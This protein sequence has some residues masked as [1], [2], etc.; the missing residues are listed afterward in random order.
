MPSFQSYRDR[1]RRDADAGYQRCRWAAVA[2]KSAQ[3]FQVF[4]GGGRDLYGIQSQGR[5]RA[6]DAAEQ[7]THFRGQ[8]FSSVR[9]IC[10]RIA[11][12]P[13]RLARVAKAIKGRARRAVE[14]RQYDRRALVEFVTNRLGMSV[15]ANEQIEVIDQHPL[16]DALERPSPSIPGWND[17]SL[18]Y[19][20]VASL[21]MTGHAYLW[22]P[23]VQGTKEIWHLPS[24]WVRAR[25]TEQGL[26][27]A[28]LVR[29]PGVADDTELPADSIAP[30]WYPDPSNPL[31]GLGPMEAGARAVLVDEFVQEAQ[32]RA[33]QMGIHPGAVIKVGSTI[34]AE[35]KSASRPRLL[36]HQ[37]D[38]IQSAINARYRGLT[39]FGEP[40]IADALVDDIAPYGNTPKQMDFGG[41]M[42]KTQ[43]R[44]EQT[45]GTNPYIAGAA[46]LGSRAEA[47]EARYQ[48]AAEV[49]NP[50]I[51]LL[52]RVFTICVVPQ[53][54]TM[55][56]KNA[57]PGLED[58]ERYVLFIE[59]CHPQDVEIDQEY[60][61]LAAQ[62]GGATIDEFRS[63]CLRLPP[64]AWGGQR[65]LM[66]TSAK[67]DDAQPIAV[68]PGSEPPADP[69][70]DDEEQAL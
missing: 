15:K 42:D 7:Y 56:Q 41:N 38:Q 61:K 69:L 46:S 65:L 19:V 62:T 37:L 63:Q 2:A 55:R 22:F 17:W 40:F 58:G 51:E 68:A 26:F 23:V 31:R 57:A 16:L 3:P 49:V 47:S 12:Q 24:H 28:W 33:F 11:G 30:F 13:I 70:A 59:P 43:A 14:P 27:Q 66:V 60:W 6:F 4:T 45:F 25:S 44:V 32:K 20:I 50:K 54:N 9:P 1:A 53:F 67:A 29:P 34:G 48:F 36:Q 21:E 18:K 8:V 10:Q 35:G 64:V 52:S 39:H 5:Q